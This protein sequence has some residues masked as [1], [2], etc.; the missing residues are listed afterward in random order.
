M[1]TRRPMPTRANPPGRRLLIALLAC[2]ALLG[3]SPGLLAQAATAAMTRVLIES[4]D[5]SAV[6]NTV[7]VSGNIVAASYRALVD[8]IEYKLLNSRGHEID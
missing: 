8:S 5:G 4:S 7:G 3:A 2:L 1:N 6:W